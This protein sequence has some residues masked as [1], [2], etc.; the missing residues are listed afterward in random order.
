MKTMSKITIGLVAATLL[1]VGCNE[2]ATP[3][4]NNGVGETVTEISLGLRK[5]DLYSETTE[6]YGDAAHYSKQAAGT[7]TKIKRAFQDAPPMIPHDVKDM[8][9]I[10]INN[11]QCIACHDPMVAKDMGATPYPTS[12]MINFRPTHNISADGK[13]FTKSRY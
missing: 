5:T 6:T 12:H 4:S 10:T 3:A 13:D 2:S 9:P 7:S 1:F 8:L 11:N